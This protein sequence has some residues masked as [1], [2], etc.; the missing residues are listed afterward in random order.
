MAYID[1]EELQKLKRERPITGNDTIDGYNIGFEAGVMHGVEKQKKET[2]MYRGWCKEH[3]EKQEKAEAE[4]D[5]LKAENAA[6]KS[7]LKKL[8]KKVKGG[9]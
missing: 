7:K 6:L 2:D 1:D 4:R 8:K 9:F 5:G 3:K